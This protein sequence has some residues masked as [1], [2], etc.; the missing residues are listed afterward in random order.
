MK[1][2]STLFIL[3]ILYLTNCQNTPK[4]PEPQ[5]HESLTSISLIYKDLGTDS[6]EIPHNV[7]LLGENGGAIAI[8]TVSVN[9]AK[10]EPARYAEMGIPADAIDA[11][12]GWYAG[13]GDYF[14]LVRRDGRAVVF[15]GFQE[16]QQ[17]DVGY[18]WAEVKRK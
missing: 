13:G 5:T 7:L 16:E 1:L 12:G 8:D 17:E 6:L 15:Q 18:H 10:I 3:I 9:L 2:T 11:C 14:Y 4:T